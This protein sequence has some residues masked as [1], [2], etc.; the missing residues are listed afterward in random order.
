MEKSFVENEVEKKLKQS[1]IVCNNE[2]LI[3]ERNLHMHKRKKETEQL[4]KMLYKLEKIEL[5]KKLLV[6]IPMLEKFNLMAK[7]LNNP[8]E[9]K[10]SVEYRNIS[11]YEI[12]E[13][14]KIHKKKHAFNSN[15]QLRVIIHHLSEN[16][17]YIWPI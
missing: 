1:L 3:N 10:I 15:L 5:H 16:R 14:L 9:G 2:N 13:I 17:E 11:H 7:D 12:V 6:L 8:I 4:R